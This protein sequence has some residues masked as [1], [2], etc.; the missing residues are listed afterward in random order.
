MMMYDEDKKKR[1]FSVVALPKPPNM[2]MS[3]D[4]ADDAL[5]AALYAFKMAL[6][7]NDMKVAKKAFKTAVSMC[8]NSEYADDYENS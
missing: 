2:E 1:G 4:M 6:G 5:S 3:E 8:L 7:E